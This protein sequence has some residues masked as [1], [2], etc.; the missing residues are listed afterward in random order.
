VFADR[1]NL[2]E[3]PARHRLADLFLDPL[4]FNAHTTASDALWAG[5]PLVTCRGATLPAGSPQACCMPS[6]Y[7]VG[8]GQPR[9]LR[10]FGPEARHRSAAAQIDTASSGAESVEPSAFDTDRF[11]RHIETAYTTMWTI[12]KMARSREASPVAAESS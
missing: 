12:G 5:L 8:D 1:L 2:D 3:H 11:R 4:P 6:A 10:G 9:R 7:Q